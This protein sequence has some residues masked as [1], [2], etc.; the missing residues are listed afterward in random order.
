M[1]ANDSGYDQE[2]AIKQTDGLKWRVLS[3][4]EDGSVNL[5]SDKQTE[6]GIYLKGANGYNNGVSILNEIC[7]KQYSNESL[8]VTARSIKLSDIENF[9]TAEAIKV[10]NEKVGIVVDE[11][12]RTYLGKYK[13]ENVYYPNLLEQEIG[14]GINSEDV[15]EKGLEWDEIPSEKVDGSS[16]N[17]IWIVQRY[18]G[19]GS[20]PKDYIKNENAYNLLFKE[21]G[22]YWIG[23][24]SV[25]CEETIWF[26]LYNTNG[27]GFSATRL[28]GSKDNPWPYTKYIRPVVTLSSN[29]EVKSGNGS[30]E[31]SWVIN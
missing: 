21:G 22:S 29:Y 8:G 11:V 20:V 24:R 16:Q 18:Y 30:S 2:Q 1:S 5:I 3:I 17:T 13:Y 6:Q 9:L 12:P 28:L 23:T 15:L 31:D 10:R 4:N 7:E 25:S 26:G 27:T 19:W 14:T